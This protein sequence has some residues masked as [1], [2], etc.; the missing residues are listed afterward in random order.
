[1]NGRE[2]IHPVAALNFPKALMFFVYFN[3]VQNIVSWPG[4][5]FLTLTRLL[6]TLAS[7][8]FQARTEF[9]HALF[10]PCTD[11]GFVLISAW[12]SACGRSAQSNWGRASRTSCVV[13]GPHYTTI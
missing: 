5:H 9:R 2:H 7:W 1:M 8:K 11:R 6:S 4:C 12:A 10:S 13:C 3:K